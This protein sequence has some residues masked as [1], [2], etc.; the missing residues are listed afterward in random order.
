MSTAPSAR[1]RPPGLPSSNEPVVLKNGGVNP[2]WYQ[3]FLTVQNLNANPMLHSLSRLN[4]STVASGQTIRWDAANQR[5][6][7]GA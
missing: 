1:E 4:L 7:Y 6:I 5:W 2:V 3:W